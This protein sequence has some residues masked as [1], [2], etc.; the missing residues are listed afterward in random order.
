MRIRY[1]EQYTK[2]A[3]QRT[4][5]RSRYRSELSFK[6]IHTLQGRDGM[7]EIVVAMCDGRN[8]CPLLVCGPEYG[9]QC[10]RRII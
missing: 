7:R 6:S 10:S 3:A 8:Q 5:Y 4:V 1:L 9:R 2:V